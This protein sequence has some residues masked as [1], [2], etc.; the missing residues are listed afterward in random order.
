MSSPFPEASTMSEQPP[1]HEQ[2]EVRA[3]EYRVSRELERRAPPDESLRG[4]IGEYVRA[5]R[6][7]GWPAERVLIRFKALV[8]DVGPV[9]SSPRAADEWEDVKTQTVGW[10]IEEYYRP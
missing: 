2:P 1:L 3:R 10:C 8:A 5:L 7:T 9:D 4:A 6:E